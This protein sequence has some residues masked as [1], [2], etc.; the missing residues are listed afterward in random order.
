[1][2]DPVRSSRRDAA[3]ARI[4]SI[5]GVMAHLWRKGE[6]RYTISL[7][8]E[9]VPAARLTKRTGTASSLSFA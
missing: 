1:M 5:V 7:K 3:K 2:D 8:K 4:S 9:R 6:S